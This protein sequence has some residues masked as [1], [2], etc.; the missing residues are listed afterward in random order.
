MTESVTQDL[1]ALIVGELKIDP[2]RVTPATPLFA[3]GLE[4][5]SFAVVDLVSKLEARFGFHL[6]DADFAPENFADVQTLGRVV[7]SYMT[8]G[9]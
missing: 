9:S 3:G 8:T 5:D 1:I 2:A 4:L 6:S 7:A